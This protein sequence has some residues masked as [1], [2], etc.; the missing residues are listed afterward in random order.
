MI[1]V[2]RNPRDTAVSYFNHWKVL[3]GYK[4]C[5]DDFMELFIHDICG[6]YTPFVGHV[7]S[8]W[9]QIHRPNICFITFE[10]MK[11]DLAGVIQKVGQFLG[12][13]V[14]EEDLPALVKHLSFDS[15]KKNKAVN[16]SDFV[17]VSQATFKY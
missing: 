7:L 15:M 13:P 14:K 12:T 1:Y 3:E 6:Y 8:Y 9:K 10:D 16:K 11:K 4:G 5:F 17:E 2:T